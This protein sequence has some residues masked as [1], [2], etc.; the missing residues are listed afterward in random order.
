MKVEL[1]EGGVSFTPQSHVENHALNHWLGLRASDPEKFKEL[2]PVFAGE[3]IK[4]DD[5][6]T[7]L[8]SEEEK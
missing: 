4:F 7:L 6:H 3:Q 5:Y 2:W 8:L 1:I